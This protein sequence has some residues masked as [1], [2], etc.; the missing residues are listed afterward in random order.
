MPEMTQKLARELTEHV[1]IGLQRYRSMAAEQL[2]ED[3][4]ALDINRWTLG[5]H[6]IGIMAEKMLAQDR[7]MPMDFYNL[8]TVCTVVAPEVAVIIGLIREIDLPE[9]SVAWLKELGM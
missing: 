6:N 4:A 8:M 5:P 3:I 7:I 1:L 2:P 9:P